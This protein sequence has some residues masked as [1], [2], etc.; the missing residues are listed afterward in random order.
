L[1][2]EK[3]PSLFPDTISFRFW[4]FWSKGEKIIKDV[5]VSKQLTTA[6]S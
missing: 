6:G 2:E 4:I 1:I 3:V 5:R